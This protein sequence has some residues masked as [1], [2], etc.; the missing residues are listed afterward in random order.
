TANRDNAWRSGLQALP[1]MD[2][3][4]KRKIGCAA[5]ASYA[6]I[7][8]GS[9]GEVDAS[10]IDSHVLALMMRD[11]P[12]LIAS[13]RIIASFGPSTIQPLVAA[14]RLPSRLKDKLRRVLLEMGNDPLARTKLD[15]AL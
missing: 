3:K 6:H 7:L 5:H 14:H 13:L 11:E 1:G 12:A 2:E 4:Q 9:R 10:A 15:H 8:T